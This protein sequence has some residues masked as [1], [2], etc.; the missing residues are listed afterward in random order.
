[1]YSLSVR[2]LCKRTAISRKLR[3]AR[4]IH[5]LR[6]CL[7]RI[8]H[9]ALRL[10][11]RPQCTRHNDYRLCRTYA[12]RDANKVRSRFSSG[13]P[14]CRLDGLRSCRACQHLP[15]LLKHDGDRLLEYRCLAV[16][17]VRA[18]GCEGTS[19]LGDPR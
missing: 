14:I 9:I 7:Y 16:Q 3:P 17:R 4:S 2:R 6:I 12:L 1:M 13:L 8:R 18:R 11:H 5:N 10:S 19:F 15:P